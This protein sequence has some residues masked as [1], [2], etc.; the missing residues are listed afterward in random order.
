[1]TNSIEPSNVDDPPEALKPTKNSSDSSP[2]SEDK[3]KQTRARSKEDKAA[4]FNRIIDA[5]KE[6]IYQ[7]GFYGFGMR[8]LA[9]HLEMSQGNLYNY[10]ENKRELWIAIRQA[11]YQDFKA[12]I[13]KI[14][15]TF[16]GSNI[17]QIIEICVYVLE[18][19]AEDRRRWS[20]LNSI[21][22]PPNKKNKPGKLERKY[23][24]FNV[25]EDVRKVIARGIHF[26]EIQNVDD[27]KLTYYL[28]SMAMGLISTER[29][30]V[31]RDSIYEPILADEEP[32][33]LQEFRKFAL[34][35][36][37]KQLT[38]FDWKYEEKSL[39]ENSDNSKSNQI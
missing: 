6:L 17:D 3:A 37:R 23:R 32:I 36:I 35:S 28:Y 25:L 18:F 26:G 20:M 2:E 9:R 34:A 15:I 14:I 38:D 29:E 1:M 27:K 13:D 24:P 22:A 16:Q 4:Q 39:N 8:S 21:P 12:G 10:V 11:F 5:G 7:K 30:I 33:D 19:A 31:V